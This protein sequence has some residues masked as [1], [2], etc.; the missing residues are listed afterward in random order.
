MRLYFPQYAIASM[1]QHHF[2]RYCTDCIQAPCLTSSCACRVGPPQIAFSKNLYAPAQRIR[3]L[4][5]CQAHDGPVSHGF[6]Y[7]LCVVRCKT[8]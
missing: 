5:A 4:C 1:H 6:P 7:C 2:G 8:A 3:Y